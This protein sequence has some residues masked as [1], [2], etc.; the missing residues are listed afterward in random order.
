MLLWSKID[1]TDQFEGFSPFMG[2]SD[3]DTF[4]NINRWTGDDDHQS[5]AVIIIIIMYIIMDIITHVYI[6]DI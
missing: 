4:S 1:S 5:S 3:A 2:E 6:Y